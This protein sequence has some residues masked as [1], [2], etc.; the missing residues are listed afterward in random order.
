MDALTDELTTSLAGLPGMFVIARNSA[1][2]YKGQPTD[3]KAIGKELGVKYALEGSVQPTPTRIRVNVQLIDAETGAHLWAESFD[4]DRAE[5]LQTED[6]IVGR[7]ARTLDL[8]LNDIQ[9]AESTRLRP[10]NPDAEDLA[11]R[12]V[13]RIFANYLDSHDPAKH[14]ELYEACE[15]ALRLDPGNT[16]ALKALAYRLY[17]LG[18]IPGTEAEAARLDSLVQKALAVDPN[19]PR[20]RFAKGLLDLTHGRLDQAM[21]EFER[22]LASDSSDVGAYGNIGWIYVATGREDK[23]IAVFDKAMLLSPRDPNLPDWLRSKAIALGVLGR[24]AEASVLWNQALTLSPTNREMLGAQAATLANLGRDDEARE[25]Y[26]RYVAAGEGKPT[27]ISD[28]LRLYAGVI[29]LP[30]WAAYFERGF[31]GLRKLGM[32]EQ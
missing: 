22:V 19:E 15:E 24:D 14:P 7:L 27:T 23:A 31:A 25:I 17:M 4:Q 21:V 29:R 32:A 1:F 3:V 20:A 9:A 5:L 2:T 28:L 16:R 8:K 18:L 13:S 11:V 6:A 12:C 26:Q 30:F 10:N